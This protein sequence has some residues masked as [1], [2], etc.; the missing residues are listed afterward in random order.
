MP[1]NFPASGVHHAMNVQSDARLGIMLFDA[2]PFF[3]FLICLTFLFLVYKY[4]NKYFLIER[5]THEQLKKEIDQQTIAYAVFMS[6]II[7]F[8]A[9]LYLSLPV[10][11]FIFCCVL[12]IIYLFIFFLSPK[13]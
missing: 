1:T 11:I 13:K 6:S 4:V 5:F 3:S 10:S 9:D 7:G 2:S 8:L 12:Y